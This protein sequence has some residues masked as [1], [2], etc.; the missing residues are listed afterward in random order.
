LPG[1]AARGQPP[2]GLKVPLTADEIEERRAHR[3]GRTLDEILR[4]LEPR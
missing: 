4:S 1:A 3:S 2:A